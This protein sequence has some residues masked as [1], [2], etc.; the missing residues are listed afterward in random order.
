MRK[1]IDAALAAA[2]FLAVV[3]AGGEGMADHRSDTIGRL[4]VTPALCTDDEAAREMT[5]YLANGEFQTYVDQMALATVPCYD[6]RLGHRLSAGN[7]ARIVVQELVG[8]V[9]GSQRWYNIY[10]A[11]DVAN[12]DT[13]Y[14]WVNHELGE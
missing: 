4:Q 3:L 12:S 9:D 5:G 6:G 2:L 13:V 7:V 8:R 10:R 11:R 1:Y 14:V